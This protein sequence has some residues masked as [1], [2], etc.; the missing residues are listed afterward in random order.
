MSSTP[1]RL[2]SGERLEARPESTIVIIC[3]GKAGTVLCC[4][5]SMCICSGQS[6]AMCIEVYMLQAEGLSTG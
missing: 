2:G 1:L 6:P 5:M 4:P 3:R